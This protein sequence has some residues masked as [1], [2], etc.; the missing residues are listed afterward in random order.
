MLIFIRLC[1]EAPILI[2]VDSNIMSPEIGTGEIFFPGTSGN[3]LMELQD[4]KNPYTANYDD[5]SARKNLD[6]VGLT[7]T[8]SDTRYAFDRIAVTPPLFIE[9][10]VGGS[11]VQNGTLSIPYVCETQEEH[12]PMTAAISFDDAN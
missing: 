3:R 4:L 6:K 12:G 5:K 8:P 7:K 1:G 11:M 10:I 2:M 9:G